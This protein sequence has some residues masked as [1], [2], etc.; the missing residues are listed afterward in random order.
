VAKDFLVSYLLRSLPAHSRDTPA[1]VVRP[2]VVRRFFPHE[3]AF[4]GADEPSL[5]HDRMVKG[6]ALE[7]TVIYV[8]D[9]QPVRNAVLYEVLEDGFTARGDRVQAY[10]AGRPRDEFESHALQGA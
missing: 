1:E 5:L 8:R 7:Y 2:A 3:N 9:Q 6:V 10:A 4:C